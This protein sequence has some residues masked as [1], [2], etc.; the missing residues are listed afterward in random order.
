MGV[1]FRLHE[2]CGRI[3]AAVVFLIFLVP[4]AGAGT[5]RPGHL[6]SRRTVSAVELGAVG[7]GRTLATTNLQSGIDQLA[8]Q[9]G[10]TLVIPRGAFLSG[11]IFLKP[12]VALHLEPG[13][14]LKAS[15]DRQD[16]PRMKTRVEGHF[17]DW[18]PALINADHVDHLR[19]SGPG[20]LDGMGAP[21]W[22]EFCAR[23]KANPKTANLDVERPGS[24]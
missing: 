9:G 20:T 15:T 21:F 4:A 11:A 5:F 2:Y 7:D 19:I 6:L 22:G 13:A 8:A 24:C 12:G 17:Q 18:L 1:S 3:A 14:V 10:G 16:Y 23:I